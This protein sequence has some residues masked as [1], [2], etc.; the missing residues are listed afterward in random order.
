LPAVFE[1][2]SYITGVF[3]MLLI[4]WALISVPIANAGDPKEPAPPVAM[5]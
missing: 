3:V 4:A 1:H 5:M 2:P